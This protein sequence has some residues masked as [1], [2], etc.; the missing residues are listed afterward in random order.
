MQYHNTFGGYEKENSQPEY[1][2]ESS[3][4]SPGQKILRYIQS[5]YF[6]GRQESN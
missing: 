5:E 6:A 1:S 2:P 4:G 3:P